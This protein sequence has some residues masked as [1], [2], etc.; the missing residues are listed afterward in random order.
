MFR[1]AGKRVDW[2]SDEP[3]PDVSMMEAVRRPASGAAS[4][5]IPV[6]T[7]STTTGG[8]LHLESGLEHDLVRL[9]DRDQS[10]ARLLPQPCRLEWRSSDGEL[11][12]HT[13]DLMSVHDN[14][15]VTIWDVKTPARASSASFAGSARSPMKAA[16]RWAGHT[17]PCA[18]LEPIHRDNLLW[19]HGYRTPP[20]WSA[21]HAVSLLER[22]KPECLLRELLQ[23]GGEPRD[24]LRMAPDLGRTAESRPQPSARTRHPGRLMTSESPG[25]ELQAGARLLAD[26]GYLVVIAV[27]RH[28][29]TVES[30]TGERHDLGFGGVADSWKRQR[31]R[32]RSQRT[33][34]GELQAGPAGASLFDVLLLR[35]TMDATAAI[36]ELKAAAS[37]ANSAQGSV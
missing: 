27:G 14:G 19:L 24:A 32:A 35:S 4:K 5:H 12:R 20:E 28:G 13:P 3:R 11:R 37:V 16:R 22:S 25:I 15:R 18:G 36:A 29:V 1:V 6:R 7:F 33:V 10:V 9:L 17:R 8:F 2:R 30:S 21:A 31:W 34:G 26:A 23:L